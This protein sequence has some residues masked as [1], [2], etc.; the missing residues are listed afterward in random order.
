MCVNTRY[1]NSTRGTSEDTRYMNSTR[2]TSSDVPLVEL[3]Y[4]VFTCMPGASYRRQLG[5]LL[6]YLCYVSQT[7]INSWVCWFCTSALGLVLFHICDNTYH[8][9]TMSGIQAWWFDNESVFIQYEATAKPMRVSFS[10]SLVHTCTRTHTSTHTNT[11]L[12]KQHT[13]QA[14]HPWIS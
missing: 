13:T 5:S 6:L 4:L 10:T 2:G 9:S 8:L 14:K 11:H 3:M 1:I 7:L 12:T